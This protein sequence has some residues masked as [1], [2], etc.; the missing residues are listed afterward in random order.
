MSVGAGNV[1]DIMFQYAFSYQYF[2]LLNDLV[3]DADVEN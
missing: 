2:V 3:C 1:Y